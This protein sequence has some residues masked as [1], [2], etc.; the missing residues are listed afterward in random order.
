MAIA[1]IAAAACTSTEY[2]DVDNLDPVLVI[3][4]QMT[5][6]EDVHTIHLSSSSRSRVSPVPTGS[7]TVSI[8]SGA[9]IMATWQAPEDGYEEF[10]SSEYIFTDKLNPGDVIEITGSDGTHTA[11]A[12]VTV[13]QAPDLLGVEYTHDVKHASAGDSIFDIGGDYYGD[14]PYSEEPPYSPQTWHE[15][16]VKFRDK[17]GEDSFYRIRVYVHTKLTTD[18]DIEEYYSYIGLDTSSEPVLSTATSSNGGL[19]DTIA[20]E[21]NRY[22]LF[23]DDLFKDKEYTLKLYFQESEIINGRFYLGG[24]GHWDEETNKWV[25]DPLP[26]GWT[27]ESEI[28]VRLYSIS[29]DQY[30]YLKAMDLGDLGMLFSEP[31][32][33]PSNVEGGMGFINVDSYKE[34]RMDL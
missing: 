23:T 11:K 27:Y 2:L 13:P 6:Q 1:A 24:D 31:V 26:E 20:E 3:N 17:S 29:Q 12:T 5:P 28:L 8:N 19:L 9:P 30:I 21:S 7:V 4:A 10:S 32:S 34:I 25:L 14:W 18:E 15:I 33:I 22:G 16:K